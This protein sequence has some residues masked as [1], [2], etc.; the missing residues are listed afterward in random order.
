MGELRGELYVQV[1]AVGKFLVKMM[2]FPLAKQSDNSRN[3]L[4]TALPILPKALTTE[5]SESTTSSH[6]AP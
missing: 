2:C 3:I 4:K 5:W 1:D 6:M